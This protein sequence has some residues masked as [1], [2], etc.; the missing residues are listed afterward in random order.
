MA[1]NYLTIKGHIKNG[2]LDV[3]LPTNV[4]DGEIEV[5]VPIVSNDEIAWENPI[6][7]EVEMREFMQPNPSTLG[8]ILHYLQAN[9][10][11]ELDY[12]TDSAAWVEASRREEEHRG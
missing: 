7:T 4:A 8:E 10:G 12:I 3:E 9:P 11:H 1:V 2:K 5:V 6:W